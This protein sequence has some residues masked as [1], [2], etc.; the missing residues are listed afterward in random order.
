MEY[1]RNII[2]DVMTRHKLSRNG[3]VYKSRTRK[4]YGETI[5]TVADVD[6]EGI[7]C[8]N[9]AVILLGEMKRVKTTTAMSSSYGLKHQLEKEWC[10]REPNHKYG[11]YI[12]N[13]DL[14]VA[15]YLSGVA[16]VYDG[17][18]PNCLIGVSF[19]HKW[20]NDGAKI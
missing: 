2:I 5:G 12:A 3:F 17:N 16:V 6:E 20:G 4:T 19:R 15:A 18:G 13:G 10:R 9:R 11:G 8:V 14:I 1:D 7:D